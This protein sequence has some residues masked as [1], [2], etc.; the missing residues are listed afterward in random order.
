MNFDLKTIEQ[1]LENINNKN[2]KWFKTEIMNIK[3]KIQLYLKK[4]KYK[5]D[6]N[7]KKFIKIIDK[8]KEDESKKSNSNFSKVKYGDL[9]NK[10]IKEYKILEKYKFDLQTKIKH[11]QNKV[12]NNCHE[13][14]VDNEMG[15]KKYN[16]IIKAKIIY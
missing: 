6:D 13:K 3:S 9:I 10:F 14:I 1:F 15:D 12:S 5:K 11:I 8:I 7:I 2:T 16:H 4:S